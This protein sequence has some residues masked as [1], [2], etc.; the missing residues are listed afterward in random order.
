MEKSRGEIYDLAMIAIC[1]Y[2]VFYYL[3]STFNSFVEWA[4]NLKGR[5]I[6]IWY[7]CLFTILKV[8][9]LSSSKRGR[10]F[11]KGFIGIHTYF[12]NDNALLVCTLTTLV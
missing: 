11:A 4:I 3:Q 12:D 2:S 6:F 9:S 1:L 8:S 5:Y 7:L 10:M